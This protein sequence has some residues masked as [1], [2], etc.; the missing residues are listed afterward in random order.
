MKMRFGFL[1]ILLWFS[2][3]DQVNSQTPT[4][5]DIEDERYDVFGHTVVNTDKELTIPIVSILDTESGPS[6]ISLLIDENIHKNYYSSYYIERSDDGVNF[7]RLNKEPYFFVGPDTEDINNQDP[8]AEENLEI[9]SYRSAVYVDSVADYNTYFYRV[10]GV[11]SLG[12]MSS[13]SIAV[14]AKAKKAK[15]D[16][17]CRIDSISYDEEEDNVIVQFPNLSTDIRDNLLGFQVFRSVFHDGP[18]DLLNDEL[19]SSDGQS[20]TDIDP[21]LSGYYVLIAWDK[22]GYEYRTYSKLMQLPD[23]VPPPVPVIED[24]I[25]VQDEKVKISWDQVFAQDLNGYYIYFANGRNGTYNPINSSPHANTEI[26]HDFEV[27]ME[28][29]SI[30]FK[31]AAVDKRGNISDSSEPFGIR[32]PG[33]YG[34]ASPVIHSINPYTKGSSGMV[35]AFSF[36]PDSDVKYHKLQRRTASNATWTDIKRIYNHEQEEY[37]QG[38]EQETFIDS[39]YLHNEELEYRLMVVDLDNLISSSEIITAFPFNNQPQGFINQL[40]IELDSSPGSLP[41]LPQF[42][43]DAGLSL[44]LGTNNSLSLSWIYNLTPKLESFVV[45]RGITGGHLIEYRTI[46]LS[47]IDKEP[48]SGDNFKFYFKDGSLPSNKRYIYKVMAQHFDGSTSHMSNAVSVK[49]D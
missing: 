43:S 29:D 42:Q 46:P 22:E 14:P 31:V 1:T 2:T 4:K 27:G 13:P 20:F 49:I 47:D 23:E 30:Y 9:A 16:F 24:A 39:T 17:I 28:I 10:I 8:N 36:S 38:P 33:K 19:I 11:S 26:L 7:L 6:T 44:P 3:F 25:Y 45:Y 41:A 37:K 18:F 32:R 35:L 48:I 34:A 15:M 12:Q 40:Q 5:L 21:L